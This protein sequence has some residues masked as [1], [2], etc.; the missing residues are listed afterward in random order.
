MAVKQPLRD[1][2]EMYLRSHTGH[3]RQHDNNLFF[4]VQALALV[5][6]SLGSVDNALVYQ[7]PAT[8]SGG[9]KV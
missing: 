7:H 8:G 4:T 3:G 5:T 1:Y 9:L 2:L 6:A